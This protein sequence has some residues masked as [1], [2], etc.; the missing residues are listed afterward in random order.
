[1]KPSPN[2]HRRQEPPVRPIYSLQDALVVQLA[3]LGEATA[4]LRMD[5]DRL[6][7]DAAPERQLK[8]AWLCDRAARL[9]NRAWQAVE[10]R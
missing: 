10:G 1:M 9:V 6:T 7:T 8:A 5:L 4:F 3:N 2:A